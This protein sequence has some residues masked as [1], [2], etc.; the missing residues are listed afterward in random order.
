MQLQSTVFEVRI[1]ASIEKGEGIFWKADIFCFP[2]SVGYVC[3][4]FL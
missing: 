1:M 2:V 3:T 4:V